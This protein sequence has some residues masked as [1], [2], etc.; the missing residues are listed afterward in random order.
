MFSM[1][2][3]LRLA[4]QLAQADRLSQIPYNVVEFTYKSE[5]DS[6]NRNIEYFRHGT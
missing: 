2:D 4:R 1:F 3:T 5:R 6:P